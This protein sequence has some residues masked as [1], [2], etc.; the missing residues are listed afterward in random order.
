MTIQQDIGVAAAM[1][2]AEIHELN[3]D[4]KAL[5]MRKNVVLS[6][7]ASASTAVQLRLVDLETKEATWVSEHP[8][9]AIVIAFG[10]IVGSFM[11]GRWTA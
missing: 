10:V 11:L 9:W 5:V 1:L 6:K 2:N 4:W 3:A 7:I 8:T